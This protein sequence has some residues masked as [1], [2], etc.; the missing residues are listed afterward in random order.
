VCRAASPGKRDSVTDS[1]GEHHLLPTAESVQQARTLVG[2][3]LTGVGFRGDRDVAM[4]LT[5]EVVTNAVRHAATPIR[6]SVTASVTS[7][8]VTVVDRDP[9]HLPTMRTNLDPL[10]DGGRGLHI[11]ERMARAWGVDR[12]SATKT[13]WFIVT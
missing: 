13:V 12:G 8:L 9:D 2:D 1:P 3:A 5:S 10:A 6:L 11:L 4:L 7:A